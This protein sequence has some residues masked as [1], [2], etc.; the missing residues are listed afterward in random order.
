[1][2]QHVNPTAFRLGYITFWKTE[3]YS[4]NNSKLFLEFFNLYRLLKIALRF[5][6]FESIS[7]KILKLN[8][9]SSALVL[10]NCYRYAVF[11][12][13]KRQNKRK[14][15]NKFRRKSKIAFI[16]IRNNNKT[17]TKRKLKVLLN[18]RMNKFIIE[19]YFDI[20]IKKPITLYLRS[21][22]KTP[23]NLILRASQ[24]ARRR[25]ME[26]PFLRR[27]MFLKD[28]IN[29]IYFS[30]MFFKSDLLAH[31]IAKLLKSHKN[32]K[33]IAK[34][35]QAIISNVRFHR[36]NSFSLRLSIFGKTGRSSRSRVYSFS[37][38]NKWPLQTIHSRLSYCL[39]QT[40]N[41][42]GSFG[43]KLWI[44]NLLEIKNNKLIPKNLKK[45]KKTNKK[46]Y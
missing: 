39:A 6:G 9:V 14:R 30:F 46:Y 21:V 43:V 32:I 33:F 28:T 12:R 25:A 10:I 40:W 3:L 29:L 23:N 7:I 8:R 19:D 36:I 4:K 34:K 16:G 41:V 37:Y 15:Y 2:G 20:V 1:M 17:K 11:K 13:K 26:F 22:F 42:K 18:Y 31:H 24:R 45:V 44:F 5:A 27:F 35:I 38:G